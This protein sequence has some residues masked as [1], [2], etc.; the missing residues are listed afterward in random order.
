M[1]DKG[2]DEADALDKI[3]TMLQNEGISDGVD[4]IK[5]IAGVET[6]GEVAATEG[7]SETESVSSS[8][9]LKELSAVKDKY[10]S[11]LQND[12]ALKTELDGFLEQIEKAMLKLVIL[13]VVKR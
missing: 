2:V 3:K 11:E 7:L 1:V 5:S 12:G 10:V 13:L 8:S 4:D 9:D 6:S